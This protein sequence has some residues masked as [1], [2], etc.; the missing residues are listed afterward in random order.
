M[1]RRGAGQPRPVRLRSLL[2]LAAAAGASPSPVGSVALFHAALRS[3]SAVAATAFGSS[4]YTAELWVNITA[5][6]Q[7]WTTYLSIVAADTSLGN[8]VRI[9]QING[10]TLGALFPCPGGCSTSTAS[11][12]LSYNGPD[13][14][15]ASNVSL[16]QGVWHHLALVRAGAAHSL[17]LDGALLCAWSSVYSYSGGLLMIG[18]DPFYSGPY[19]IAG[20]DARTEHEQRR[21]SAQ[22]SAECTAVTAHLLPWHWRRQ[23]AA[24]RGRGGGGGAGGA[25]AA[26]PAKHAHQAAAAA[27]AAASPRR[28]AGVLYHPARVGVLHAAARERRRRLAA[29]GGR[30]QRRV[31]ERG[32]T[33]GRRRARRRPSCSPDRDRG[34]EAELVGLSQ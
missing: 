20:Q 11:C 30:K 5:P 13:G 21:G 19:V 16:T 22:C 12:A 2:A 6:P 26:A 9:G 27:A 23:A 29:A 25:G 15:L 3:S 33:C 24:R 28:A 34:S 31:D 7:P 18:M 17:F 10:P 8:E 4:P 14:L 32:G 1:E